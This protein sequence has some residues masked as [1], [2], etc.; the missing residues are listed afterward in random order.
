MYYSQG[1]HYYPSAV[2]LD[3]FIGSSNTLN[4]LYNRICVPNK[5]D[6]V[7]LNVFNLITGIVESKT[8][9]K[10]ISCR[11]KCKSDGRKCNLNQKWDSDK[12]WCEC[13]NPK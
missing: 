4:D 12:C 1:L 6:N 11:C 9:T 2:N 7:N 13:K 10:H 8:L 5:T 3:R